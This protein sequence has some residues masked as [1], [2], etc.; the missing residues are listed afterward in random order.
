[1]QPV[2]RMAKSSQTRAFVISARYG[3]DTVSVDR[4][5]EL[6]KIFR[7]SYI[8]VLCSCCML[9]NHILQMPHLKRQRLIPKGYNIN[10][11]LN[12]APS[13]WVAR[14]C[15]HISRGQKS[16]VWNYIHWTSRPENDVWFK[17]ATSF[18]WHKL[19]TSQYRMYWNVQVLVGICSHNNWAR[20]SADD[21]FHMSNLS[22]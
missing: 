14:I 22:R 8:C 10:A 6:L 9:S 17:F 13:S 15:H 16:L 1:M 19:C 18:I 7:I 20:R 11:P 21:I 2:K 4:V 3:N 5:Y 12:L